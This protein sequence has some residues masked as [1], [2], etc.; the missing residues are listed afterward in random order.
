MTDRYYSMPLGNR[1][2]LCISPLTDYELDA[3][4]ER[5][6]ARAGYYLYACDDTDPCLK[7]LAEVGSEDAA[8]ELYSA[9]SQLRL[10]LGGDALLVGAALSGPRFGRLYDGD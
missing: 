8:L 10:G 6:G 1:R 9:L 3:D 4:A 7:I 2:R 5:Q